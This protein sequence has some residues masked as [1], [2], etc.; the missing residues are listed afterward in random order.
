MKYVR[1]E[2]SDNVIF[3]GESMEHSSIGNHF[4]VKSA[5]FC[6][7]RD[8][9]VTCYGDSYSLGI[10]SLEDDS[11]VATSQMFGWDAALELVK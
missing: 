2:G 10:G 9:K 4:N 7:V 8:K 5:G 6:K 11:I 1:L 3:F